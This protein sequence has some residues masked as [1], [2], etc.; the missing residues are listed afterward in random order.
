MARKRVQ[1]AAGASSSNKGKG[2]GNGNG[3]GNGEAVQGAN[4]TPGAV[5]LAAV[6]V[7]ALV[8]CFFIRD[9]G[10]ASG[11]V[12]EPAYSSS[13]KRLAALINQGEPLDVRDHMSHDELEAALGELQRTELGWSKRSGSFIELLTQ[14]PPERWE[15][16]KLKKKGENFDVPLVITRKDGGISSGNTRQY[17]NV[18]AL[19]DENPLVKVIA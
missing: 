16:R 9:G 15:E 18:T 6:V 5:Q 19:L 3:N 2:K 14:S 10:S 4:G 1:Q 12:E 7:V 11:T 8:S 13:A 17:L